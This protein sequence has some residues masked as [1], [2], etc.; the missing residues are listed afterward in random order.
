MAARRMSRAGRLGAGLATLVIG[1]GMPAA[2]ATLTVTFEGMAFVPAR[3]V[4]KRGDTLVWVNRD[5][6][7][8]TAT[9]ARGGFDS[10][11][12]APGQS[13]RTPAPALGRHEVTCTFHPTMKAELVV[14]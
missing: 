1:A 4:A 12:I 9:V 8:H 6:V 14:E 2:A 13:W 10:G 7:P 11:A 3:I 5:L